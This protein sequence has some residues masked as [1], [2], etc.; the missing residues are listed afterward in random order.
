[1]AEPARRL[2][3]F[4]TGGVERRYQLAK[5]RGRRS[6]MGLDLSRIAQFPNAMDSYQRASDC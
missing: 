4:V 1:M 6:A 5:E 2:F 3:P